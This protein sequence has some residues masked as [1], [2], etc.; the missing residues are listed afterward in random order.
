MAIRVGEER[1]VF[2]TYVAYFHAHQPLTLSHLTEL[3][4]RSHK[5][6]F[7]SHLAQPQISSKSSHMTKTLYEGVCHVIITQPQ[8]HI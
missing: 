1:E 2:A 5:Y 6:H 4:S 3:K 8:R 7:L